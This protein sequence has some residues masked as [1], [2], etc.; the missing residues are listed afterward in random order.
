VSPLACDAT[1]IGD[2]GRELE[3]EFGRLDSG[4][5]MRDDAAVR[6]TVE[7]FRAIDAD[8]SPLG[9]AYVPTGRVD[10]VEAHDE[11][12][13]AAIALSGDTEALEA[14]VV[15]YNPSEGL[16]GVAGED[17]AVRVSAAA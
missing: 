8:E 12:T 16:Y 5:Q 3:P 10:E 15:S 2:R 11:S 4:L 17:E 14:D 13:A 9:V 1:S 7:H 6:Y